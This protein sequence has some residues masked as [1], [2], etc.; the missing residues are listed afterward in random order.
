MENNKDA[1]YKN[2]SEMLSEAVS[3]SEII[4]NYATEK[5]LEIQPDWVALIIKAKRCEETN[6]WDTETEI[7]F[8]M[9][10]KGLSKLIKPVTI[11]SLLSTKPKF[12]KTPNFY[13]KFFKINKK[14]SFSRSS[15][16]LYLFWAL[17]TILLVLT[18]QI[19]S[20]KGTTL[21]NKIQANSER[22][23]KIAERRDE[24]QLMLM[25]DSENKRAEAEKY[26][27]ESEREYLEQEIESSVEL[28]D[29]W[30]K[31]IRKMALLGTR[32]QTKKTVSFSTEDT[33]SL[34]PPPPSS[35]I[36][37][38]LKDMNHNINI[39]QEAQNFTQILQLYVL[40]LLYG[41]MGGFVFVLRSLTYDIKNQIFSQYSNIKYSLRI[42]LGALAGL[43]VGLLWGDIE[44]Q[45]ITFLESLS[46]AGLA[47][48]AGYGVEYVFNG[49]DRIVSSISKTEKINQ[50]LENN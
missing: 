7:N 35:A 47:F 38:A 16:R 5:G 31:T 28:L 41:L 15:V 37:N 36:N 13:Q 45:Q 42:H 48:I 40:P 46:T 50:T 22:I 18:I 6:S 10:Y 43:I 29:P 30:V 33:D 44:K 32:K 14:R 20:L 11:D 3:R 23:E 25:S 26:R 1:T 8:W 24:I 39:I 2:V 27:L 19:F 4:L 49:I 9:A 17:I 21:L 12:I 34:P